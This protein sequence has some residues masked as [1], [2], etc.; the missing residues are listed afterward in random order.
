V[1]NELIPELDA[2]A[3]RFNIRMFEGDAINFEWVVPDTATWAGTYEFKVL[4]GTTVLSLDINVTAQG[5]DAKFS[6]VDV[7]QPELVATTSGYPWDVHDTGADLTRFAGLL[8]VDEQV[9]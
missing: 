6:V 3:Q 2:S 5:L 7:P 4:V 9:A 1:S 8:L